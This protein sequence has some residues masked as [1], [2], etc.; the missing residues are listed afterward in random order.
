MS[1]ARRASEF[2]VECL[3]GILLA[4]FTLAVAV[5]L[6]TRHDLMPDAPWNALVVWGTILLLMAA[7]TLRP[8]GSLRRRS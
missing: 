5:P 4:G 8:R 3:V 1:L 2:V 7:V 6:L